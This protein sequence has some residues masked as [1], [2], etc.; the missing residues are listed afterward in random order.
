[1]AQKIHVTYEFDSEEELRAHFGMTETRTV[2]SAAV[3]ADDA[4][5][6]TVATETR[7]A[8]DTDVDGMPYDAAIH[9]DPPSTTAD[10]RWRAKRGQGE[11]AKEARAAFLAKGGA[12]AAP[13]DLPATPPVVAEQRTDA[14]PG[15]DAPSGLPGMD[16]LPEP[17]PAPVSFEDLSAM[18]AKAHAAGV[19]LRAVYIEY[20]GV[21]DKTL[22]PILQT[23]ET[24]RANIM[25]HLSSVVPA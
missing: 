10:G 6:T 9:A 5:D 25:R 7:S 14:L 23:N 1:M 11:A 24:V 16:A 15:T 18:L 2:A 12:V 20:A 22:M 17:A 21:A 19:D 4:D 8:S 3:V 13:T